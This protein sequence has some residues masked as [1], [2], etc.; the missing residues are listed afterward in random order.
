MSQ[1]PHS[2]VCSNQF[3]EA[4]L[5]EALLIEAL[6]IEALLIEALLIEA[7]RVGIIDARLTKMAT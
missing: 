1:L 4:L 3:I 7:L 6:L 2:D 5:I